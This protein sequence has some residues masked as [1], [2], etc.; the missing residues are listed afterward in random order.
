MITH[1]R[2]KQRL[3]N[4]NIRSVTI[5]DLNFFTSYILQQEKKDELLAT[6]ISQENLD[7]VDMTERS[8]VYI[9]LAQQINRLKKEIEEIK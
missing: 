6:Y 4:I 5:D 1:S 3:M 9:Q 2:A 7:E 8:E